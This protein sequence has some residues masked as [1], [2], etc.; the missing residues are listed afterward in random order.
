MTSQALRAGL[1]ALAI[2]AWATGARA[3]TIAVDSTADDL[4][5][6]PNGNCTLR[7]AVIAANTDAPVDGCAAGS[8]ADTIVLPAGTFLLT[9]PHPA[10]TTDTPEVGDL[11][12]TSDVTIEGTGSATTIIDAQRQFRVLDIA[13]GGFIVSIRDLA[14]TGGNAE[15][16]D[17]YLPRTGGGIRSSGAALT[18]ERVVLSSNA[19]LDC[20]FGYDTCFGSGGA[21]ASDGGSIDLTDCTIEANQSGRDGSAGLTASQAQSTITRSAFTNNEQFGFS[22]GVHGDTTETGSGAI[23]VDG[24]ALT[25][26]E[27]A[28]T[29]NSG[30][31][32]GAIANGYWAGTFRGV[33]AA[34]TISHSAFANN[35][36]EGNAGA[37]FVVGGGVTISDSTLTDNQALGYG[38]FLIPAAGAVQSTGP[39]DVERSTITGN[40]VLIEYED[41]GGPGGILTT[42]P[43]TVVDSALLGN[44]GNSGGAVFA[45]DATVT[46]STI[47]ENTSTFDCGGLHS[48]G[49]TV[50]IQD[51][52]ISDNWSTDGA[53]GLCVSGPTAIARST[54][55]RNWTPSGNYAL[56][57]GLAPVSL[58]ASIIDG[59]CVVNP[60]LENESL[61]GNLESPG[62]TCQLNQ[63]S[64]VVSVPDA[65]LGPLGDHGGLTPTVPLLPGSPAIDS[66]DAA[67]CS[68]TDQRGV[69][70]P[71]DGDGDGLA[72]CDRGAFELDCSGPDADGDGIA[73][74]CDNCPMLAN[75]DQ[76]DSNG[77]YIGDVCEILT[78]GF[79]SGDTSAW[80]KTVPRSVP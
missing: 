80:T 19:A 13:P 42:G 16:D 76:L 60:S 15:L 54:I 2:A 62:D 26:T 46:R 51:S 36:G 6:G 52:T 57:V 55:A 34:V 1:A 32:S 48:T 78:D 4:D 20:S 14:I 41:A 74:E 75:P 69:T 37:V 28:F 11:D 79:E 71:Q 53:A 35:L 9:I 61:G 12:I 77:N 23:D 70:R 47:S 59:D 33:P 68:A 17:P 73:D 8:G 64:D 50:T 30:G 43:L 3:A 39:V 72:I 67:L 7:E 44:I 5:Q 21:I 58:V 18:I 25:V 45:R 24:G 49:G 27:S 22:Y 29:G 65:R 38:T 63:P 10:N 40:L 66:L 56:F 31:T